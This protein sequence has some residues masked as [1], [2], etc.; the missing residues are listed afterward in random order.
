MVSNS[1]C[2]KTF[3]FHIH[4]NNLNL[5]A[6]GVP[7][8]QNICMVFFFSTK[9]IGNGF[10]PTKASHGHVL[11]V[12]PLQKETTC[13]NWKVNQRLSVGWSVFRVAM[14]QQNFCYSFQCQWTQCSFVFSAWV[15]SWLFEIP[16]AARSIKIRPS[17][18]SFSLP[19]PTICNGPPAWLVLVCAQQILQ[20]IEH[21]WAC[22]DIPFT[23]QN[24]NE[25]G[26]CSK[27]LPFLPLYLTTAHIFC[28]L[29]GKLVW[30]QGVAQNAAVP[31]VRVRV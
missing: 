26:C 3:G 15:C 6:C 17:W 29:A 9:K 25:L 14:N 18:P 31:N 5:D 4:T 10:V 13:C 1:C 23:Y 19:S 2:P 12:L 28:P 16:A 8:F 21:T 24:V 30:Q 20:E 7:H 22:L 27:R 11:L